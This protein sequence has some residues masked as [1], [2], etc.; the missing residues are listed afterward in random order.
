MRRVVSPRLAVCLVLS[1]TLAVVGLAGR[2]AGGTVASVPKPSKPLTIGYSGS[3]TMSNAATPQKTAHSYVFR[4]TWTYWWTGTW[5]GL[6]RDPSIFRSL[7]ARFSK[8]KIAGRVSATYKEKVDSPSNTECS[9]DI[10]RDNANRPTVSASYDSSAGTLQV[11]VEAPTFRG[12]KFVNGKD[13]TCQVGPGVNVFGPGT[14]QSPPRYFNPL[15][16]GGTVKLATGGSS[17]YDKTWAWKHEFASATPPVEFRRYKVSIRS[18]ITVAYT[19][20]RL[21]DACARAKP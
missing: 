14:A 4:V 2:S 6:F 5:G 13:P 11:F 12:I 18:G 7:P 16:A 15:G 20:C 21:I 1:A 3:F 10:V 9:F 8:V 17:R 19:P